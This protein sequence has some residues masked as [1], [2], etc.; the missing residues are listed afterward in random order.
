LL[1]FYN[2]HSLVIYSQ[3]KMKIKAATPARRQKV[4]SP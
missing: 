2:N 4:S 1:D 3:S